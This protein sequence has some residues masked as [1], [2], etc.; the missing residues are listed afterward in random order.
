MITSDSIN[1]G[2][3]TENV[4]FVAMLFGSSVYV[5]AA[6]NGVIHLPVHALATDLSTP[7]TSF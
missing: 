6:E 3:V 4:S 7:H 2:S 5:F 1:A